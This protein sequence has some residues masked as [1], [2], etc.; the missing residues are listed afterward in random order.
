M[1]IG[2]RILFKKAAFVLIAFLIVS[3]P[4]PA[5]GWDL[6]EVVL[7][8]TNIERLET[9]LVNIKSARIY[10]TPASLLRVVSDIS[11]FVE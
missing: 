9:A 5:D 2:R 7:A 3:S 11:F 8:D 10:F 1:N 6:P 4:V